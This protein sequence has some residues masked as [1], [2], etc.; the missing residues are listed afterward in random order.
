VQP[1]LQAVERP[2]GVA[3]AVLDAAIADRHMPVRAGLGQPAEP[4]V[5]QAGDLDLVQN[6]VQPCQVDELVLMT[7]ARPAPVQS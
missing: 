1:R 4:A 5:Q 7:V 3:E 6:V 2:L